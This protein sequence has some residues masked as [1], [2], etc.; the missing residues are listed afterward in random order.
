MRAVLQSAVLLMGL[1]ALLLVGPAFAVPAER[2]EEQPRLVPLEEYPVYDLVIQN[3]LLTSQTE[4]VVIERMTVTRLGPGEQDLPSRT[5]FNEKQLFEGNLPPDLVTDFVLKNVRPSRLEAQF[6][7]GIRYRFVTDGVLEEPEVSLA[8]I[9]VVFSPAEKTPIASPTIGTM[10]LSRVGFAQRM[11]QAL[12]Y[13]VY[14][15]ENRQDRTGG[16][17][18]FLLRRSGQHWEFVDSEVL[19]IARPDEER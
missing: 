11:G 14:I 17:F 8:P 4:L 6:N 16:G 5:Y 13:L 18:L 10:G 9:P 3:K 7:F 15:E 12:V 2:A 19:W 1:G